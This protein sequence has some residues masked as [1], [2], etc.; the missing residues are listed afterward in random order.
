VATFS[1]WFIEFISTADSYA[2]LV[3]LGVAAAIEYIFPPFPGDTITLFGAF[4]ITAYAWSFPWVFA[5]VMTGSVIGSMAAF[6]LGKKLKKPKDPD[7]QIAKLVAAFERRGAILLLLNRFLPGI[8]SVFFVAAGLAGLGAARV[9]VYS[10]LSAAVW[11]LVLIAAGLAVGSQFE[12]LER[13]LHQYMLGA[14]IVLGAVTVAL[15]VR[16]WWRKRSR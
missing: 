10:A 9:A 5:A 13:W 4:L 8:R 12:V 7:G 14:W 16:W 1:D 15:V 2:G 6:F 3:A 11:N